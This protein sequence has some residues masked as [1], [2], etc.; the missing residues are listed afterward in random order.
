MPSPARTAAVTFRVPQQSPTKVSAVNFRVSPRQVTTVRLPPALGSPLGSPVKNRA[1]VTAL[2][3][4]P[5]KTSPVKSASFSMSQQATSPFKISQESLKSMVNNINASVAAA[6]VGVTSPAT[7]TSLKP[8][9][10]NQKPIVRLSAEPSAADTPSRDMANGSAEVSEERKRMI[11]LAQLKILQRKTIVVSPQQVRN[12]ELAASEMSAVK[13]GHMNSGGVLHAGGNA[14]VMT[15]DVENANRCASGLLVRKTYLKVPRRDVQGVT[16]PLV[17]QPPLSGLGGFMQRRRGRSKRQPAALGPER[18]APQPAVSVDSGQLLADASSAVTEACS[19]SAVP[20][21]VPQ[22]PAVDTITRVSTTA[23]GSSQTS[24]L[25][26]TTAA[27]DAVNARKRRHET[28]AE[29]DSSGTSC[30][31]PGTS[32]RSSAAESH[33][34]AAKKPK[35]REFSRMLANLSRD[36]GVINIMSEMSRRGANKKRARPADGKAVYKLTRDRRKK[37]DGAPKYVTKA[38]RMVVSS[39]AGLKAKTK[40][41]SPAAK[42]RAKALLVKKKPVVVKQS[43][44]PSPSNVKLKAKLLKAKLKT[45]KPLKIMVKTERKLV[46]SG[47][48]KSSGQNSAGKANQGKT[49]K[50]VS[51][52][53]AAV[54]KKGPKSTT[55][56]PKQSAS[57]TDGG[58]KK[59]AKSTIPQSK[60]KKPSANAKSESSSGKKSPP[61]SISNATATKSGTSQ[62]KI[63]T[64]QKPAPDKNLN[65][66]EKKEKSKEAKSGSRNKDTISEDRRATLTASSTATEAKSGSPSSKSSKSS[67]P[68]PEPVQEPASPGS[69]T[70]GSLQRRLELATLKQARRRVVPEDRE[71]SSSRSNL[72]TVRHREICV[73]KFARFHQVVLCPVTT[74]LRA[75]LN[76]QVRTRLGLQL[77]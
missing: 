29:H 52:P 67:T 56:E 61:A 19:A 24:P 18:H 73:K 39:R 76:V 12:A 38:K 16:A 42:I 10:A 44:K 60:P 59:G 31:S 66:N 13:N 57:V 1:V 70:Y 49:T 77:I 55:I 35:A 4:S 28:S 25:S 50:T 58:A 6:G 72:G 37:D 30:S 47:G 74:R 27:G 65:N 51:P 17:S 32:G 22:A 21:S 8:S 43:K 11:A 14:D 53:G 20:E 5:V 69:L 63:K 2:K 33:P 34:P 40:L 45:K 75:G 3:P 46:K 48:S 64:Q 54:A 62:E 7:A 15:P 71:R 36:E 9:P 41:S 26:I 23:N 68:P